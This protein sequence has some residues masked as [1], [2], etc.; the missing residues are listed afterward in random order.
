MDTSRQQQWQAILDKTRQMA[1]MAEAEKWPEL[2]E[3]EAQRQKMIES[4]FA[5]K[6]SDEEAGLIAEGI[7]DIMNSDNSLAEMGAKLKSEALGKLT[8]IS[9][10]KKAVKAYD[11]CR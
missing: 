8:D 5:T 7:R 3:T 2:V 10:V 11:N 1:V 4:F 9:N 6:V